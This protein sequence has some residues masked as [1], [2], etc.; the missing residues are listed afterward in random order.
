M[1]QVS[2]AC[3]AT[4]VFTHYLS[5]SSWVMVWLLSCNDLLLKLCSQPAD[6]IAAVSKKKGLFTICNPP[7]VRLQLSAGAETVATVTQWRKSGY[8]RSI[9][10]H[11][12]SICGP[13]CRQIQKWNF[14]NL[15]KKSII[16]HMSVSFIP[17][18]KKITGIMSSVHECR[19]T[20]NHLHSSPPLL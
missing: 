4:L 16:L 8:H 5:L 17:S 12:R 20:K 9:I 3:T 18:S 6:D 2:T 15:I 19:K 7:Y 14:K 13:L 10:A 11:L 1:P